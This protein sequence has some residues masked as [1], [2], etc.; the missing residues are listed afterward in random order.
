MENFK[1]QT[2]VA[3]TLA[4]G[5]MMGLGLASCT[6]MQSGRTVAGDSRPQYANS[7]AA[8][9]DEK[10]PCRVGEERGEDGE[11]RRAYEFDRPFRRGGR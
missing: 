1:M 8:V 4:F 5:F 3:L 6:S 9:K 7:K 11:C 2:R 10:T